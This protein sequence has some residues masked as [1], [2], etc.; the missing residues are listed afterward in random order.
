MGEKFEQA[1]LINGLKIKNNKQKKQVAP[2]LEEAASKYLLQ[3]VLLRGKQYFD[4]LVDFKELA[5]EF[6]FEQD[7]VPFQLGLDAS[8]L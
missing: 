5:S 7:T 4:R 8:L 6:G 3:N 2:V 1:A